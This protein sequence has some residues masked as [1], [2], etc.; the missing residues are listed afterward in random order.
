MPKTYIHIAKDRCR[1][2]K[3]RIYYLNSN[4]GY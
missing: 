3:C 2:P 4:L 1:M